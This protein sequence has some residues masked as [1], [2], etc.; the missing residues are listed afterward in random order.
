[1][2]ITEVEGFAEK[3]K[4]SKGLKINKDITTVILCMRMYK[5]G[6]ITQPL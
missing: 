1:M 6:M 5:H 2:S 3:R 4:T